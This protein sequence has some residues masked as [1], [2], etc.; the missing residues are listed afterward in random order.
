M[1]KQRG[2]LSFIG[3]GMEKGL[4]FL[5][6]E[7]NYKYRMSIADLTNLGTILAQ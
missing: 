6:L 7:V 1:E 5:S 4:G 2:T 3:L